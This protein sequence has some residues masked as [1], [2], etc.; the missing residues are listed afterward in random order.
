MMR[1]ALFPWFLVAVLLLACNASA[2]R[3]GAPPPSEAAAPTGTQ[4]EATAPSTLRPSETLPPPPTPTASLVPLD[5]LSIARHPAPA[6]WSRPALSAVPAFDPA[7]PDAGNFD[8]RA[9][10]LSRLD[11]S[12]SGEALLY[13]TFDDRTTW[14]EAAR[15]PPDFDP[16]QIMELGKDP[17]LGIRALHARG[18]TGQGVGIAI[19]DQALL[20]DHQEYTSQLRLYEE[21]S[22]VQ[23]GWR[24]PAMHGGAVASIAVGQTVGVAPGAD[25]YYIATAFGGG[26]EADMTWLATAIRRILELNRQ[27]PEGRRIRVISASIGWMPDT[28]GYAEVIAAAEEASEAG[29]LVICSSSDEVHGFRLLGLGREPLADPNRLE[30]YQPGLFWAHWLQAGQI[31]PGQLLVPM[32]SRT[33]ASPLGFDEYAFYRTGGVSW[34]IPYVAGAYALAAQVDPAITPERFWSLALRLGDKSELEHV[35]RSYTLETVLDLPAVID[36]L[37][38]GE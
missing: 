8:V 11:L 9:V 22:D 32:D 31:V 2:R 6:T 4:V 38:S 3:S 26:D 24:E 19:V 16:V 21:L 15:L 12:G 17:G 34:A 13:A 25:L 27:L 35:G 20:V 30:S 18:I 29:L 37:Q 7:S 28:I 23:G 33:T 1:S 36:A 14:P 10:D 5:F